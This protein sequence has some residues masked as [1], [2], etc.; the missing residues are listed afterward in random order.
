MDRVKKQKSESAIAQPRR[1]MIGRED[2]MRD[3]HFLERAQSAITGASALVPGIAECAIAYTIRAHHA[4]LH[5][6]DA[7]HKPEMTLRSTPGAP[8]EYTVKGT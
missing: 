1:G 5:P 7:A 6:V 4:R 2:V 3:D 8:G